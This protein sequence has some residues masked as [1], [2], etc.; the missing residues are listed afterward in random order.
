MAAEPSKHNRIIVCI[1]VIAMALISVFSH[2]D[3]I[4]QTLC[5][6]D[7]SLT[8]Q[9]QDTHYSSQLKQLDQAELM[10]YNTASRIRTSEE[11][12]KLT[13]SRKSGNRI[14]SCALC[15]TLDCV[16]LRLSTRQSAILVTG[17][18]T[19]KYSVIVYLHRSDGQKPDSILI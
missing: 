1:L 12:E 18:F 3:F 11:S 7:R 8:G 5:D 6:T 19:P 10:Q 9:T 17:E 4:G 14:L 15:D 13:E 2:Q 16:V